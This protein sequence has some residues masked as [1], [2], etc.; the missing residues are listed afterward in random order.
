MIVLEI[1]AGA[2]VFSL[3]FIGWKLNT[4]YYTKFGKSKPA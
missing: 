3:L 4:W 2:V 1:A